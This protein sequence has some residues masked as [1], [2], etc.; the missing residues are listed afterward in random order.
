MQL[1]TAFAAGVLTAAL[2]PSFG[3]AAQ[4]PTAPAQPPATR[5]ARTHMMRTANS[6]HGVV[7][8]APTGNTFVVARRG[9]TVTVDAT[10]ATFKSR[11]QAATIDM[12]KSGTV[13][14]AKGSMQA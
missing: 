1:R 8:G 3:A 10:G 11:T 7:K 4:P 9:G 14:T 13:V 12:I 2:L 6:V 5:P